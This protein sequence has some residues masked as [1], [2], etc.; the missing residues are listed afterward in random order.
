MLLQII[1]DALLASVQAH[2]VNVRPASA[3]TTEKVALA[4]TFGFSTRKG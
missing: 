1:E 3:K 4:A 2:S